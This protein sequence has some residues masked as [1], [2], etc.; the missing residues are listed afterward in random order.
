MVKGIFQSARG[1]LSTNKNM[2][3]IA[4]NLANLNTVGF[5]REGTFSEILSSVGNPKIKSAIDLSQGEIYETANPLDLAVV[6]DGVFVLK[7]ESGYE[8]TRNGNFRIS[9]EGLLV[10]ENG[11]KVMGKRGE[12]NF[13]SFVLENQKSILIS[14]QGEIKIGEVVA[15]ELMLVKINPED[16]EKRKMGLNFDPTE[17][18]DTSLDIND[19]QIMQG[20]LEESNVNPILEM[21]NMINTSKDY[22]ASYKMVTYLDQTLEKSNEIGRI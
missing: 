10:N 12:I 19:Y 14:K 7:T 1:M 11:H 22:E 15:D 20:Y 16:Y 2:E 18:V 4:N 5:K 8:F 3:I 9:E 17:N 21:E 6:G 13:S